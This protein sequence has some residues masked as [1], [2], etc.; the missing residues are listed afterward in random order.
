[1]QGSHRCIAAMADLSTYLVLGMIVVPPIL[2]QA[3][4]LVFPTRTPLQSHPLRPPSPRF[5]SRDRLRPFAT[6]FA[7][8]VS[9]ATLLLVLIS[10]RNLIPVQYRVDVLIPFSLIDALRRFMYTLYNATSVYTPID[11]V[12]NAPI[13]IELFRGGYSPDLFLAYKAPITI[14]T[15]T[16]RQL[17]NR[18]PSLLPIGHPTQAKQAGL[19]A[20]VARLSSYEAR[21]MYLLLGPRPLLDCTFCKTAS[22]YFCYALPF[23]IKAYAWRILAIGLLPTHPDDSV[24]VA[25]RLTAKLVRL[26]SR[27]PQDHDASPRTRQHEADRSSWRIPALVVL[28][29]LL[30]IELLVMFEFGSVTPDPSRFNHWHTN[31]H[32]LRQLGLLALVLVIY[33]FPAPRVPDSFGQ[34]MFH[35]EATQQSLQSLLH[36]SDLMQVTRT[37]VLEDDRLLEITRR[38]RRSAPVSTPI[39]LG[40]ELASRMIEVAKERGGQPAIEAL[41]Q[42]QQSIRTVTHSVWQNT[43]HVNQQLVARHRSLN[44][45]QGA[46]SSSSTPTAPESVKQEEAHFSTSV[47]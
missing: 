19:E 31:L 6:P 30:A 29:V 40:P 2:R 3:Q 25:I 24:A 22:D 27:L 4:R 44:S 32:I 7:T 43:A 11:G 39:D 14:P 47:S 36:V 13:R 37:V 10:L 16:L 23:L 15:T 9:V 20:L 21:R 42:A 5:F 28:L 17:I 34:A 45:Q 41:A 12:A 35:L 26:S 46:P 38:A 18:A 1:M 33:L 8:A